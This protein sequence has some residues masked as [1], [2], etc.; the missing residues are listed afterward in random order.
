MNESTTPE[1][2]NTLTPD[3]RLSRDLG[4]DVNSFE[5]QLRLHRDLARVHAGEPTEMGFVRV[6]RSEHPDVL[7]VFDDPDTAREALGTHPV[8][9]DLATTTD[10]QIQVLDALCVED[11][12][13][14]EVILV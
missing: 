2:D 8:L 3:E 11:L 13:S 14:T 4:I 5:A 9:V 1:S 7:V 10:T 6:T 12:M